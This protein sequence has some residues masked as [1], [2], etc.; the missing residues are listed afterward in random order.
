MAK[1]VSRG[2]REI[3][4]K[5]IETHWVKECSGPNGIV[6]QGKE[7]GESVVVYVLED[8]TR[9]VAC[10]NFAPSDNTCELG[11]KEPCVY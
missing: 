7:A 5:V 9:E 1:E 11:N 8:I 2:S 3:P 4:S 10:K 6:P